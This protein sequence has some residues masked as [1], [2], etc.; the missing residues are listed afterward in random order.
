MR[1]GQD[2]VALSSGRAR[3]LRSTSAFSTQQLSPLPLLLSLALRPPRPPL[4]LS[5]RCICIPRI[6]YLCK[7]PDRLATSSGAAEA[8]IAVSEATELTMNKGD[9]CFWHH[10]LVHRPGP[11]PEP[12]GRPRE[13]IFGRW[14]HNPS[15][16][17]KYDIGGILTNGNLW[18]HYGIDWDS[19]QSGSRL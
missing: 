11:A 2:R 4:P 6:R 3:I 16:V 15:L 9:V 12:G 8:G 18:K 7:H 1:W 14:H 10:W 17:D 13:A 5:V 19:R